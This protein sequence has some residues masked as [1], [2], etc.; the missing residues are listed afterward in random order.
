MIFLISRLL[1]L[2]AIEILL[3]SIDIKL[4]KLLT[5]FNLVKKKPVKKKKV[6]KLKRK[7]RLYDKMGSFKRELY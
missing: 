6:I 5:Y 4:D 7:K 1:I 2:L 3:I